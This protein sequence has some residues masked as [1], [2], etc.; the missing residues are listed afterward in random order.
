MGGV[1]QAA[2]LILYVQKVNQKSA[3]R[4]PEGEG[5]PPPKKAKKRRC[6]VC[7]K[8]LTLAEGIVCQCGLLLC[9]IHRYTD[10]HE[11]TFDFKTEDRKVI[12]KNNQKCVDDKVTLTD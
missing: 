5:A 11:C 7:R 12:E 2:F 3:E 6:A 10:K 9:G 8:K 1:Q 4:E